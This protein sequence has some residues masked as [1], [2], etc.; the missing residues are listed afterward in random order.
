MTPPQRS[1]ECLGASV[2]AAIEEALVQLGAD[3]DDVEVEVLQE[4]AQGFLGIGGREAKVRVTVRPKAHLGDQLPG[5]VCRFVEGILGH[6]EID[7][8]VNFRVEDDALYI[9][10]GEEPEGEGSDL[11]ILIGR[12][13]ETLAALQ[14]LVGTYASRTAG[15]RVNMV[16]DA[17]HYR[18][19]RAEH[20]E[21]LASRIAERV[22]SNGEPYT[23]RPMSAAERR[24][25]HLALRNHPD[26]TTVSEGEE[27]Y[28]R[29]TIYLTGDEPGPDEQEPLGY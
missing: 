1:V 18:L 6:M 10:I 19:R 5:E 13:G 29:L 4:G 9:D 12:K 25:V 20:L 8:I 17:A 23:F 28:R 21:G 27:P 24:V 26:V 15:E 2:E 16:L 11:G 22:L 14:T 3:R 7:A